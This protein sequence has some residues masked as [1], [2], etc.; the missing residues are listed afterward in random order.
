MALYQDLIMDQ[1]KNIGK[2]RDSKSTTTQ[3]TE[4]P[5][6]GIEGL[7]M[8]LMLMNMFK[9]PQ[10]QIGP[11]GGVGDILAPAVNPAPG[12]MGQAAPSPDMLSQI[13]MALLGAGGGGQTGMPIGGQVPGSPF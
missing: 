8:M 4:P 12:M 13:L 9:Q 11:M 7:M 2:P 1:I 10:Q 3:T 5:K 6:E